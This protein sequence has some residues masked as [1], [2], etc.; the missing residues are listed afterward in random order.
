[1]PAGP[2]GCLCH[3]C[4]ECG[5]CL[6]GP[7][8][9]CVTLVRSVVHVCWALAHSGVLGGQA[10]CATRVRQPWPQEHCAAHLARSPLCVSHKQP[11]RERLQ[12]TCWPCWYDWLKAALGGR[13]RPSLAAVGRTSSAAVALPP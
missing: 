2:A 12:A 8:A 7:Q 10:R 13:W 4:V 5:A 9:A 1:M 6:L 11:Q 3:T